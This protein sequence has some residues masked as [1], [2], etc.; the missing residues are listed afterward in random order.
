MDSLLEKIQ[1][2]PI[3][4]IKLWYPTLWRHKAPFFIDQ[5]Y[6]SFLRRCREILIGEY[7]TLVT[8]EA[9]YFLSA[10]GKLYIEEENTYFQLYGFKGTPFLLGLSLN[11]FLSQNFVS[12]I[13]IDLLYSNRSIK[14]NSYK[15]LFQWKMFV[16]RVYFI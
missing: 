9:Q 1:M 6:D 5:F 12:N 7:P 14:R 16:L 10:K 13:D 3:E 8:K 15:P 11:G 4:P 2:S